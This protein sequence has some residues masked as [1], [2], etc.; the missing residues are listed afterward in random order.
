MADI[1]EISDAL[2]HYVLPCLDLQHTVQLA[3]SCRA[4]HELI[5]QT[6]VDQL[7]SSVRHVL[8]PSGLTCNLPLVELF[9][10]QAELLARLR[11][12]GGF[13]PRIQPLSLPSSLRN[14]V[15]SSS[16]CD[17]RTHEPPIYF[18]QLVWSPCRGPE[19]TSHWLLLYAS[20]NDASDYILLDAQT[21]QHVRFPEMCLS[22]MIDGTV[23][24]KLDACWLADQHCLLLHLACRQVF[25][26]REMC[27]ADASTNHVSAITLPGAHHKG[28]SQLFA[29]YDDKGCAQNIL[30]WVATPVVCKHFEDHITVYDVSSKWQPL[31][32]LSCPKSAVQHFISLQSKHISGMHGQDWLVTAPKLML[33]PD[34]KLLATAWHVN[35]S[36]QQNLLDKTS[37]VQGLSIHSALEGECK[38]SMVLMPGQTPPCWDYPPNWVPNSSNLMYASIN[39]LHV[40]SPTGQLVWSRSTS[41][42]I[43]HLARD[44]WMAADQYYID[45]TITASECG[46]WICVIDELAHPYVLGWEGD[47]KFP[48]GQASIVEAASGLVLHRHM[49]CGLTG[50]MCD[51]SKLGAACLLSQICLSPVILAGRTSTSAASQAFCPIELLSLVSGPN[52]RAP[53]FAESCHGQISPSL[54]PCGS[55]V[56]GWDENKDSDGSCVGLLQWRLPV[57]SACSRSTLLSL[58]PEKVCGLPTGPGPPGKQV[59]WHPLPCAYIYATDS[60][61]GGVLLI[62]ARANR[63]IKSWSEAELHGPATLHCHGSHA[64]S[65]SANGA[66]QTGPAGAYPTDIEQL[67]EWSK[68]GHMLTVASHG[69]RQCMA[70]CSVLHF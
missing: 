34:G 35:A 58:E 26:P 41:E 55:N 17:R 51:W 16:Q 49:L 70:R 28:Y 5:S 15:Q 57:A 30:A 66:H 56:I 32:Q 11:C 52:G 18:K 14:D 53:Q 40:I 47:D 33:S 36:N 4:W 21:G 60:P 37:E 68:D 54:S 44:P 19:T 43:P 10:Q 69:S 50:S 63:C 62:D 24:C 1:S 29:A 7:S 48:I 39:G 64:Y 3:S 6:T 2:R 46:R 67:L 61:E 31:Y 9:K 20:Q 25:D 38:L 22:E 59:A 23:R 45:T 65:A 42:R 27:L 12:N 13:P 8:L